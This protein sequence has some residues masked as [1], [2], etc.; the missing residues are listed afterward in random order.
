MISESEMALKRK[1]IS[2]RRTASYIKADNQGQSNLCVRYAI[3]KALS[4]YLYVNEKIDIDHSQVKTSL[5]Q[6][7]G[8]IDPVDPK[9]YDG[10]IVYVQDIENLKTS[11]VT[12][13]KIPDKSWWK[14]KIK[15][16][17]RYYSFKRKK[18]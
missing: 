10:E 4:H 11:K 16:F 1:K 18:C 5:V 3:A 12:R 17:K 14:V 6:S 2:R 7:K 8:S 9:I 15:F 13:K